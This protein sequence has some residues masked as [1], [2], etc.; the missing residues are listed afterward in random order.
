M[1][2]DNKNI[3]KCMLPY[4]ERDT[5]HGGRGLCK[6]HYSMSAKHVRQ[7]L[8][9]WK[10]IESAGFANPPLTQKQKNENQ[11]H[12]RTRNPEF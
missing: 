7:G 11:R 8:A 5:Y 6:V 2:S 1:K 9:T 4:C 10:E 12:P 3:K